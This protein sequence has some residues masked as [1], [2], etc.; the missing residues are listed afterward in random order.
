V[1]NKAGAVIEGPLI[2]SCCG[3]ALTKSAKE[4]TINRDKK[5]FFIMT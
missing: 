1:S 3:S 5:I 4:K 2:V